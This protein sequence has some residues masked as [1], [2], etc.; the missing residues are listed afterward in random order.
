MSLSPLDFA[1]LLAYLA[2]ALGAGVWAS[3]RAGG[4][5]EQYFLAGR[6]L[7]GWLVGISI[8][9]TT[10]AADTPLAI[11]GMVAS[12]G[13]A[14]NWFWWASGI[15]H[16]GVFLFWSRL[17]RRAEVV[18]D[19]ELVELRYGPGPGAQLRTAKAL[20]FAVLYNGIVLGWVLRAMQKI[21]Q[22]FVRW[23]DWLP[24]G[25]WSAWEAVAPVTNLGGAGDL[26]T[27]VALVAL[28]ASYS[29]LGGL[30]GVVMTDLLQFVLAMGGS[31]ALA[32][33]AL[34]HVGG[35]AALPAKLAEELGPGRA[36][37][38]LTLVPD[39][40]LAWMPLSA[41][42]V[43]LLIR[44]WAHPL[45]DG[46]GYIAQRLSAAKDPA[47]A[48]QAAG[49]FVVLHYVVRPWPWI[50]VGLAG[51]LIFPPGDEARLF[52]EGAAVAGDRESAYPLLAGLLLPPGLLGLL[53]ASLAAAFMSTVDT[54]LNWGVSYLAHDVW[55]GRL[56][57]DAGPREVVAVARVGSV[58]FALL[59]VLA[60]TRIDSVEAAWKFV[61]AMGSG[62]GL[63][64]L[65]RWVWWRVNA[66]AEIAGA[67]ASLSVASALALWAPEG[68]PWEYELGMAVAAGAS[69]ALAAIWWFD[70]PADD[71]L[72]RFYARVRPPGFWG[73]V[74]ARAGEGE[75]R[76]IRG[77]AGGWLLGATALIAAILAPGW[78]LLGSPARGCAALVVAVAAAAACRVVVRRIDQEANER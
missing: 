17:W 44:W 66:Q 13:I 67:L 73:P 57:P 36:A 30:R 14:A 8:V 19:A 18:T 23:E 20:F 42:S 46:G 24:A 64:V 34:T 7:P 21:A 16:V 37:E 75:G 41:F 28:A 68:L 69:A 43:Y 39:G 71:V 52:A 27:V 45:G 32:V 12:K 50:L 38:V 6:S 35:L 76:G 49:V 77:L 74:A 11:S 47:A 25:L 58:L 31:V 59:A 33:V 29:T 55:K 61:A 40:S 15:A 54:H 10:F 62:L 22:P 5:G 4:S 56:R 1:I 60:A 72:D 65:L 70:P 3:R 26:L 78:L 48:R 2:A 53:L 9:A 63:P 51:M